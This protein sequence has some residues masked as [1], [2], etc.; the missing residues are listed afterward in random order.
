MNRRFNAAFVANVVRHAK[1]VPSIVRQISNW[2]TYF[3]YY[4]GLKQGG[5]AYFFRN[6]IVIRDR[7][8]TASGTIAVVFIRRQYGAVTGKSTIVEIGANIGTFSVYAASSEQNARIYSYEPVKTNY[9]VLVNNITANGYKDR[10]KTFNLGV[11]SRAGNRDFY[12][13]SSPEHSMYANDAT[14]M[15]H[16]VACVTLKDILDQNALTKVDL[17][18]INAEGAEYEIL[19]ATPPEYFER[20]DEIRLEYHEQSGADNNLDGLTRFLAACG[21]STTHLYEHTSHE[22]FLWVKRAARMART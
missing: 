3:I 2:P 8:G 10:I 1:Y 13:S 11:A 20:I 16:T 7:E 4:L 6:G 21:Y 18:K 5:G 9:D 14:A 17:L 19:Y 22:G 15:R 12:L